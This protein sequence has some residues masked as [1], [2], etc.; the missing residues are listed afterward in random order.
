MEADAPPPLAQPEQ[1]TP[2]AHLQPGGAKFARPA[3]QTPAA[4]GV[5]GNAIAQYARAALKGE[6]AQVD[7]QLLHDVER[8][9]GGGAIY[10]PAFFCAPGDFSALEALTAELEAQPGAG[11]EAWSKHLKHENPTFSATFN[12]LVARMAEHF[13][14]DVYATRLNFY[15]D[16][17]DWKPWHHDS[18]AY[19]GNALR[20]DFT[21]GG[22]FGAE[23]ELAFLHEPSGAQFAFPQR[24]GDVFAFDTEA[25]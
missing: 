3:R 1:P 15:R 13:D 8:V 18:H 10:L 12:A 17:S 7:A 11:M 6:R 22:S 14:V 23:R 9:L 19:G 2:P 4:G 16:A 25:R 24:N 20:E 21:M 5:L